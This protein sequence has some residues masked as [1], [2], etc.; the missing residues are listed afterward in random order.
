MADGYRISYNAEKGE[1][2]HAGVAHSV[3]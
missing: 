2:A 3:E 1:R